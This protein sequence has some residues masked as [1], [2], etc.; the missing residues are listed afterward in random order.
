MIIKYLYHIYLF[1][2]YLF[3]I[4]KLHLIDRIEIVIDMHY[5]YSFH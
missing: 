1:K 5:L 2:T 4:S 3:T